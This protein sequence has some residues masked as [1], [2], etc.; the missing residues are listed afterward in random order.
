MSSPDTKLPL[1]LQP[2][3]SQPGRRLG[4]H[5]YGNHDIPTPTS[6]VLGGDTGEV[7]LMLKPQAVQ[8]S[9]EGCPGGRRPIIHLGWLF[10]LC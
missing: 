5:C 1:H 9:E 4:L 2:G 6:L 10:A 3:P 7:G 8:S